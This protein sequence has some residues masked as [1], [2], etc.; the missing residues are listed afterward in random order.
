MEVLPTG[1]MN[2][3]WAF[4]WVCS[5]LVDIVRTREVLKFDNNAGEWSDK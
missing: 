4:N 5:N 1:D 2:N 3:D